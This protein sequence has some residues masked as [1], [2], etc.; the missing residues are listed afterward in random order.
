MDA[1]ITKDDQIVLMHDERIDRT[2]DGQGLIEDL[3]LEELKKL[4]AAHQWSTDNGKT[5]PY[6]GQGIQ[7]T[8]LRELF[9]KFPEK[10]Y[11]IEIKLTENPI[12]QPLCDL[13]R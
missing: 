9:E 12:H 6:R 5:F 3:T 10:R 11:L 4:D 2:T 8:A 1:H 7:V 13:I